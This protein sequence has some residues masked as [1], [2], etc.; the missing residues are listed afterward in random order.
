MID[1]L[2][3]FETCTGAR[4]GDLSTKSGA[5]IHQKTVRN[6]AARKILTAFTYENP[7]KP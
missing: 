5:S 3:D 4:T 7:L 6:T 1:F 2:M